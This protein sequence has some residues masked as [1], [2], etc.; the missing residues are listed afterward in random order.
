MNLKL[1]PYSAATAYAWI[2]VQPHGILS[3]SDYPAT[4]EQCDV[5]PAGGHGINID[6]F[7][8]V[9]RCRLPVSKPVLKAHVVSALE[10]II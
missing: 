7:C 5:A 2:Q 6:G 9:G 4:A 3:V 1:R 10:A 8:E